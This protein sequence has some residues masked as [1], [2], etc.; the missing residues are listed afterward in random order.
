MQERIIFIAS[1]N[2]CVNENVKEIIAKKI[3]IIA[4]NIYFNMPN[5]NFIYYFFLIERISSFLISI[6]FLKKE[7]FYFW[8]PSTVF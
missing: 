1:F 2:G 3:K 8:G 4:I 5:F 7:G 6:L